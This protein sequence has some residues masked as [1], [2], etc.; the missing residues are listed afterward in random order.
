MALKILNM[1]DPG[2]VHLIDGSNI[3]RPTNAI[4]LTTKF[5]RFF[6]DFEIYFEP[7]TQK[8]HTYKIIL[9]QSQNLLLL[10]DLTFP[11]THTLY[12]T[13]KHIIDPPSPRLFVI[14]R[15]IALT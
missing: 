8:P 5:H 4:T 14:R 7:T 13:D 3:D 12:L 11:I 2:V 10:R 15:A 1:F 6:G 9:T